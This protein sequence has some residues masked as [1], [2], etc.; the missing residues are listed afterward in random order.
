M[1]KSLKL[2]IKSFTLLFLLVGCERQ[3]ESPLSTDEDLNHEPV[4]VRIDLDSDNNANIIL[5]YAYSDSSTIV[6]ERKSEGGF[7]TINYLRKSQVIL[8]DTS[9]DTETSHDFI[10]RFYVKKGQYRTS[11]SNEEQLNYTSNGL[12]KPQN[13]LFTS[14]ELEGIQ[15][16]WTD[17]SNYEENYVIEKDEGSGFVELANL[18]SNSKSYFDE[19]EGMQKPP[20]QLT[21]RVKALNSDLESEWESIS[22]SYAG[23]GNPTDLQITNSS[24]SN[25]TIS[26]QDNSQIETGYSIERKKDDGNYS[27]EGQVGTD[28]IIYSDIIAELGGYSYRVRAIKDGIYSPYSNEVSQEIT[29]LITTEGLVAYYTFNGN[30]NDESGNGNDGTVHGASLTTDRFGN[31]NNAYSFDGIDDYIDIGTNVKPTFPISVSVWIKVKSAPITAC[32]FRND[33]WTSEWYHGC[34]IMCTVDRKILTQVGSG[35]SSPES[36]S[37]TI[38][39]ESVISF[40]NWHHLLIIFYSPLDHRI[41]VDGD[42]ISAVETGGEGTTMTYSSATGAIGNRF[43]DYVDSFIDDIRVFNTLLTIEDI[44]ALYYEG[45]WD[46]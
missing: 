7:E 36:R 34:T 5:D 42:Y 30:A 26:W 21:Y 37:H 19:I 13:L 12:N 40:E 22:T 8:T 32:V 43:D 16:S 24:S 29:S 35:Q 15:L 18:P 46:E 25:F 10:Y 1:W 39:E 3:W 20:I 2:I 17:K 23:I 44:Q 31:I 6:L 45:G 9:F 11:Y 14:I 28:T 38:T 4:I 33:Q 27:E 41:Y